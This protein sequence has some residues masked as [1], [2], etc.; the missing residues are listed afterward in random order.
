MSQR[1]KCLDQIG[2]CLCLLVFVLTVA[3]GRPSPVQAVPYL[4]GVS[5][6]Y[7]RKLA[8]HELENKTESEPE[9]RI[10]PWFLIPDSRLVFLP[11]FYQ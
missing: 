3:I 2:L 8:E 4:A 1:G 7:I 9:N 10:T 11:D 6:P 5:G